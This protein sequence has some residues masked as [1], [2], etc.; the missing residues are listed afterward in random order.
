MIIRQVQKSVKC[1]G[2]YTAK[3]FQSTNV[4]LS[5]GLSLT[6]A[7]DQLP[8]IRQQAGMPAQRSGHENRSGAQCAGPAQLVKK[9]FDKLSKHFQNVYKSSENA[10]IE[11]ERHP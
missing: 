8:G 1:C 9:F 11:N 2:S 5:A 10:V 3:S 4:R 7:I 6:Q